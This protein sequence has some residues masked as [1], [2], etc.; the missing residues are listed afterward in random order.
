VNATYLQIAANAAPNIADVFSTDLYTGNGT[1]QTITN[2]VDLPSNGGLVWIKDRNSGAKGHGLFDTERG[3]DY[4]LQTQST[5]GQFFGANQI[6]A[7]NADGFSLGNTGDQNGSGT[8]YA[9]WT[10]REAPKF[11]DVVTY[12][13]D[14]QSNRLISHDLSGEVG[15]VIIKATNLLG[16]W[17]AGHRASTNG[18]NDYLYFNDS[19]AAADLSGAFIGTT[20]ESNISLGSA[21]GYVNST[22]TNYVA[23]IF[24]H[25]DSV[26]GVIQCGSYVG[27]GNVSGP[28]VTLGWRPQ[29]TLIKASSATG[30]W[31]VQDTNRRAGGSPDNWV[32]LYANTSGT[33]LTTGTIKSTATG[34]QAVGSGTS[35]NASGQ[36]YIYCAIREE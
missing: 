29:W 21:A 28:T 22:G 35:T 6:T 26:D 1:T 10:F 8:T 23:Y 30:P 7:F 14:N 34:F 27:N 19:N 32:A 13:G 2:G 18:W 5:G 11:F 20:T 3:N 16:S 4:K 31:N 33:E 17:S 12:T 25:D 36:T 9:S 24:A 15:M